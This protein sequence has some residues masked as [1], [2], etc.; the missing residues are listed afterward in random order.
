MLGLGEQRQGELMQLN[1][2]ALFIVLACMPSLALAHHEHSSDGYP[3]IWAYGFFAACLL[4]LV[5]GPYLWRK[6]ALRIDRGKQ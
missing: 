6:L 1:S 2:F 4:A 5:A 3:M